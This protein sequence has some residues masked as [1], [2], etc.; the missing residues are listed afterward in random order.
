MSTS[1]I[2]GLDKDVNY[3]LADEYIDRF[4]KHDQVVNYKLAERLIHEYDDEYVIANSVRS[5]K[6]ERER[7]REKTNDEC[8][9]YITCDKIT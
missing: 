1:T 5:G 9:V 8:K 2:F 4:F 7:E 3:K 6:R